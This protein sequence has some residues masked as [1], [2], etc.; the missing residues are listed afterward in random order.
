MRKS[1]V[2]E[3]IINDN[4]NRYSSTSG[5]GSFKIAN[6]KSND[7]LFDRYEESSEDEKKKEDKEGGHLLAFNNFDKHHDII[8]APAVTRNNNTGLISIAGPTQSQDRTQDH[9]VSTANISESQ[10]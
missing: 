8:V 3:K 9:G 4:Q 5:V 7:S 6:N 10:D 2:I 1:N